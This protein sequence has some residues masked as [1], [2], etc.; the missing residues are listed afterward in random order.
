MDEFTNW[1]IANQLEKYADILQ[2]NDITSIDLLIELS[3]DDLKELN[4][5]L[6]DRKRFGIAAVAFTDLIAE[7]GFWT[8]PG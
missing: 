3:E 1:L 4:F 8:T 7:E 2:Q 5:S 6:G